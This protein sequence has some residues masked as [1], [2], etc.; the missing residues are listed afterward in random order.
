MST[1]KPFWEPHTARSPVLWFMVLTMFEELATMA[2]LAFT[3]P[4][5]SESESESLQIFFLY[6]PINSAAIP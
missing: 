6:L 4:S 2:G 3:T 1:W 5:E